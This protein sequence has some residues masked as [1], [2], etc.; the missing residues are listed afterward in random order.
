ML[1]TTDAN[2]R[3]RTWTEHARQVFDLDGAA[4]VG[5]S[6]APAFPP[7]DATGFFADLA[8]QAGNP[9][10]VIDCTRSSAA[11]AACVRY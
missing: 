2:G 11:M 3:V 10:S 4:A 5:P 6:A 7:S 9:Q 1:L 8:Q